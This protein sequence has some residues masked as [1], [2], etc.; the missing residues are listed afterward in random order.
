MDKSRRHRK[1]LT[2]IK[3][4]PISSQL[5]LGRRLKEDGFSVTQATLSRDLRELN[6]VKTAQGYKLPEGLSRNGPRFATAKPTI[7][8]FLNEVVAIGNLLVVKTDPG[9]AHP[10]ALTLDN[11]GWKE[12]V[13]TVAGDDTIL[14]VTQAPRQATSVRNR[15]LAML[16]T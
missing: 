2:L 16:N 12:I 9:G 15:L 8:Q 3:V 11:L 6:L 5:E 13:G 1:I 7:S 4:Q 10:V 14:V